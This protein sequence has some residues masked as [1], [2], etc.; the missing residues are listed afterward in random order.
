M[1]MSRW[2]WMR[3][4]FSGNYPAVLPIECGCAASTDECQE[5]MSS[6]RAGSIKSTK[7]WSGNEIYQSDLYLISLFCRLLSTFGSI[8][9]KNCAQGITE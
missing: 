6:R 8:S 7:L 9:N 3:V 1:S 5:K 2:P 4:T